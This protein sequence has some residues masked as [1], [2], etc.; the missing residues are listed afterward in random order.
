MYT[1]TICKHKTRGVYLR[2]T[3]KQ[4]ALLISLVQRYKV[5]AKHAAAHVGIKPS[6][7]TFIVRQYKIEMAE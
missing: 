3:D 5:K 6:T 7:G 1:K 4:K 2:H